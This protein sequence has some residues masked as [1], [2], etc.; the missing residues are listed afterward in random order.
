VKVDV[1]EVRGQSRQEFLHVG[2]SFVPFRQPVDGERVPQVMKPGLAR[3]RVTTTDACKG[4]QALE[5]ALYP[6]VAN[7]LVLPRLEKRPVVLIPSPRC[8]QML[9]KEPNNIPSQRNESGFVE[10]RPPDG[11]HGII[12]VYV[13]KAQPNRF[14]YSHAGSI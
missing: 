14:S 4:S 12:E 5:G 10:L 2:A 3:V 11:D 1:S 8:G 7:G 13:R 6:A 9:P